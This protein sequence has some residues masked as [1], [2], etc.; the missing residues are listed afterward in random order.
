VLTFPLVIGMD[1]TLRVHI[2][3]GIGRYRYWVMG[4]KD[5]STMRLIRFHPS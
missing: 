2:D 4:V 1:E 5:R 3:R